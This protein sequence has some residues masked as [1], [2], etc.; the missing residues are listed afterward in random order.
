MLTQKSKHVYFSCQKNDFNLSENW[1][2]FGNQSSFRISFRQTNGS[3][4]SATSPLTLK[5]FLRANRNDFHYYHNMNGT[6]RTMSNLCTHN[7]RSLHS[8]EL[9]QDSYLL[10]FRSWLICWF[11]FRFVGCVCAWKMVIFAKFGRFF[12]VSFWNRCGDCV[13]MM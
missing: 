3:I 1:S 13:L 11:P 5:H 9:S 4:N 6:F 10:W 12:R 7:N 2:T 8:Y